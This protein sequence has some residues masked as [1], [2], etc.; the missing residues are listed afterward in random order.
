MSITEPISD[1]RFSE[2]GRL[3]YR[4][5]FG[6]SLSPWVDV[7]YAYEMGQ[8]AP[9]APVKESLTIGRYDTLPR[10]WYVTDEGV[11][12]SDKTDAR[13]LQGRAWWAMTE[14]ARISGVHLHVLRACKLFDD[15]QPDTHTACNLLG[16]GMEIDIEYPKDDGTLSAT[17][18][19]IID[20]F[21][22]VCVP[23]PDDIMNA[24]EI[25][26][27]SDVWNRLGWSMNRHLPVDDAY[28]HRFDDPEYPHMHWKV[29]L[30]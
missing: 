14:I 8:P 30:K 27:G 19:L 18:R 1:L 20:A 10:E 29:V 23:D 15:G 12:I 6:T 26:M 5:S 13:W 17:M 2:N 24:A 16:G 21:M 9:L 4:T 25:R 11:T 28:H 3:Q 7:P 22:E